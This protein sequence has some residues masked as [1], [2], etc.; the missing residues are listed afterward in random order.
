[1]LDCLDFNEIKH[2]QYEN[3]IQIC[4]VAAVVC[5]ARSWFLRGVYS[6]KKVLAFLSDVF[7]LYAL[8]D[9]LR[10]VTSFQVSLVNT[11]HKAVFSVNY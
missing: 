4:C 11:P 5:M 8:T 1:M 7:F 2:L 6:E 9:S 10:V 3:I